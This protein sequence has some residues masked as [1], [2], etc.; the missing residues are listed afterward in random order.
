MPIDIIDMEVCIASNDVGIVLTHRDDD[1]LSWRFLGGHFDF[2]FH[3]TWFVDNIVDFNNFLGGW[4][5]KHVPD[6]DDIF[7]VDFGSLSI[8]LSSSGCSQI[9]FFWLQ[10][11]L[12]WAHIRLWHCFGS[13]GRVFWYAMSNQFFIIISNK[14]ITAQLVDDINISHIPSLLIQKIHLH[15]DITFPTIQA[16]LTCNMSH[17]GDAIIWIFHLLWWRYF[18]LTQLSMAES[19]SCQCLNTK[20]L[21]ISYSMYLYIRL[22]VTL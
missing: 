3:H 16:Y 20:T 9:I 21:S 1:L 6:V 10:W 2:Q 5:R 12:R 14:P 17:G 8:R 15:G 22:V 19:Y 13:L 7:D 11:V 4:S 18:Y